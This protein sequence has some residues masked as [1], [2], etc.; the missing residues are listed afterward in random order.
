MLQPGSGL[1]LA[2]EA[3]DEPG[4][5]GETAVQELHC[6]LASELLVLVQPRA[7]RYQA[8][9]TAQLCQQELSEVL[10]RVRVHRSL[11]EFFD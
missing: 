5:L 4:V 9:V 10:N 11:L 8:R 2:S 6:H 1:G 7:S 3:L